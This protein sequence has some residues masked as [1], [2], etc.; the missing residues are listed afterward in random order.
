M[1][2]I[3]YSLSLAVAFCCALSSC[4]YDNVDEITSTITGNIQ[5]KGQNLQLRGSSGA[6]QL[7]LYQ[8]G[9]QLN[10]PI[11]VYANQDGKFSAVVGDGNYKIVTRDNNGPW[12]NTRDTTNINLKGHAEVNIEVTPYFL[13]SNPTAT[14]SGNTLTVGFTVQQIVS[15]AAID[16]AIVCVGT[17]SIVDEQYNAMSATIAASNVKIGANTVSQTLTDA[18][19]ATIKSAVKPCVRVGL[20][21]KGASQSIYTTLVDLAK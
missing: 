3:L 5:Y 14:L 1:K 11:T 4:G 13:L 8:T 19:V 17:T 18:Q 9:Y 6:I 7:M 20:R 12:V 15:T 10:S 16:H 21:T 2:K